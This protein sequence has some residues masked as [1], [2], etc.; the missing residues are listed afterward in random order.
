MRVRFLS[1]LL[2][3]TL[4]ATVTVMPQQGSAPAKLMIVDPGHFHASLLQR[5]MYPALARHVSVYAP[6]GPELLDYLNRVSVFNR[7]A[8]NPTQWDLD[9]HTSADPMAAMLREHPGNAVVFTGKNRTKIDRIVASLDAGLHVFADKPW[10][11]SSSD[12]GKLERALETADRKGL[13]A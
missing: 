12:M 11:I 8:D 7:R 9:V 5:E 3:L 2:F 6:L 1:I 4:G 13:A 10:I